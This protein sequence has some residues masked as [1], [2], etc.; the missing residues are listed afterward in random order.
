VKNRR[1]WLLFAWLVATAIL[2]AAARRVNW[3][4]ALAVTAGAKLEWLAL[5]VLA[6][7]AILAWWAGYW[8]LLLPRTDGIVPYGRM[9]EIVS[10]ASSVMNTV[11]FGAGHVTGVVLLVKRG[12]AS[13]S[14]ALS[15]LALDQLGEGIAKISIWLLAG[16]LLPLPNWMHTAVRAIAVA[17]ALLLVVMIVLAP[18]VRALETM[19]TWHRAA[20]AL[21]C[22]LLMKTVEGLAIAAVQQSFGVAIPPGG[23]VLVL[24]AVVLATALP[25][26][27]GNLGAYEA[28]VFLIYRYLGVPPD[29]ALALAIVQHFCFM[30]PAVGIG[31]LFVSTQTLARR[32]MASR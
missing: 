8:K 10:T 4:H 28:A 5:A 22:V 14:G 3:T 11:P 24:A 2:V 1:V 12:G 18:R 15:V 6:N 25:L 7:A 27:P 21:A 9:L 26:A 30:L 13:Q 16:E 23:T 20:G 31:Y 29:R 19:R 32:A 17:V